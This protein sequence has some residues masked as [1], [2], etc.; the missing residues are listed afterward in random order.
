[1]TDCGDVAERRVWREELLIDGWRWDSHDGK[2]RENKSGEVK[3][4]KKVV[5]KPD[6]TKKKT[7]GVVVV[8]REKRL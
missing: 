8:D 6:R 4:G 1:L 7:E 5:E 3:E 2:P